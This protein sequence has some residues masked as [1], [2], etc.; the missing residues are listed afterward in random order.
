MMAAKLN[1]VD[2]SSQS[3]YEEVNKM[4]RIFQHL[5]TILAYGILLFSNEDEILNPLLD[6]VDECTRILEKFASLHPVYKILCGT[7]YLSKIKVV[8]KKIVDLLDNSKLKFN[9]PKEFLTELRQRYPGLLYLLCES[10]LNDKLKKKL[11]F[12]PDSLENK[13][14]DALDN[15]LSKFK[16]KF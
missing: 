15:T 6:H 14:N 5:E 10:F 7:N 13:L 1:A 8:I 9:S 4:G 11:E 3:A 2:M 16:R 12:L